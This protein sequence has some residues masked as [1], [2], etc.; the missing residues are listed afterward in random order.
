MPDSTRRLKVRR[1]K[2]TNVDYLYFSVYRLRIEIAAATGMDRRVFL[3][4]RD[5]ANPY[6]EEATDTFFSVC[7]R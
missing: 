6:T 1:Y 5:P 7:S 4:R 2:I 3:Y